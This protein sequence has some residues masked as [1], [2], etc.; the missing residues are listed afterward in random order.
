MS[1]KKNITNIN[2]ITAGDITASNVGSGEEVFKQKSGNDLEFKT[3]KAGGD[4]VLTPS[5][6]EIEIA[7]NFGLI[8]NVGTGAEIYKTTSDDH[9]FKSLTAGNGITITPNINDIEISTSAE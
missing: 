1:T 6:D 7:T 8:V 5:N 9:E 4:I 2:I 3:L